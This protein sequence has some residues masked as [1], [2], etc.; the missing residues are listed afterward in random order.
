MPSSQFIYSSTFQL[1][2]LHLVIAFLTQ[3]A[4]VNLTRHLKSYVIKD[5]HPNQEIS[6]LNDKIF[7]HLSFNEK[8]CG[9]EMEHREN[10]D[11]LRFVKSVYVFYL[12]SR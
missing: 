10:A 1:I 6:S 2:W 11:L 5:Q 3:S 12:V 8:R 7:L 4:A 9:G